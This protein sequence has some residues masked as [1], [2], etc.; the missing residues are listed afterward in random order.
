[1]TN[2]KLQ[3]DKAGANV[4]VKAKTSLERSRK[5]EIKQRLNAEASKEVLPLAVGTLAMMVSALSNQGE[6]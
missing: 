1:M 6:N 2:D 3:D 5:T 4:N